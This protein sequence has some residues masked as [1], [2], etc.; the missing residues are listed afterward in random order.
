MI[1]LLQWSV[2]SWSDFLTRELQLGRVF[3]AL[4]VLVLRIPTANQGQTQT[5][6]TPCHPPSRGFPLLSLSVSRR[7]LLGSHR[8]YKHPKD[9]WRR[10]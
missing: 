6:Q 7:L 4:A 3:V 9:S 8:S 1:I 10:L 5:S 2:C